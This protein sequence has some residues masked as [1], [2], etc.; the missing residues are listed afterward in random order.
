MQSSAIFS[1]HSISVVTV[2]RL[3]M[4]DR[5]A[6]ISRNA[7]LIVNELDV[8]AR[9]LNYLYAMDIID[10]QQREDIHVSR[11]PIIDGCSMC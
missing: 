6:I 9:L 8:D 3:D 11:S 4:D 1:F 10:K 2:T 7:E 5:V